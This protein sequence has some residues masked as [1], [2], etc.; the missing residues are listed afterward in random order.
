MKLEKLSDDNLIVF[1]NSFCV[2][3]YKFSIKDNLEDSFRNFLK[4]LNKYYNIETNGYYDIKIYQ[5]NI[6][7]FILDIKKEDIDFYGYYDDH[8]DMKISILKDNK[9]VFEIDD[10]SLVDKD[11]LKDCHLLKQNKSLYFVPKQ[12][13]NQY[14]LGY[15]VENCKIIYGTDANEI[16]NRGEYINTN[17]VFV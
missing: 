13:I 7:G 4:R 9:F 11:V 15:I 6:Y 14:H 8:I 16:L 3:K 1:L 17:K 12:T 10:Y 5:D 2:D